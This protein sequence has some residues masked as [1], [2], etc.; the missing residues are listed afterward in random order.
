MEKC[1]G[2]DVYIIGDRVKKTMGGEAS[3]R[4][5]GENANYSHN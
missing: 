1:N 5:R 4:C 3:Y 2:E